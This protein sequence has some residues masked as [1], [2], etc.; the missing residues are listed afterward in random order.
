MLYELRLERDGF[1]IESRLA[2]KQPLP[3]WAAE[4]PILSPGDEVFLRAFYNLTTCRQIGMS[5][6]PIPW[7]D[8][9][10]YALFLELDKDLIDP[11]I[12]IIREM[13]SGWLNWQHD[14]QERKRNQERNMKQ[15]KVK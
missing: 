6:G 10:K 9:Y 5:I 14:E 12:Q 4:E 8:I 7:T 15:A 1:S 2:K 11:F 3:E 13:D